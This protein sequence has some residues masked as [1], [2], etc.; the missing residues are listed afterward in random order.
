MIKNLYRNLY[1]KINYVKLKRM[2]KNIAFFASNF[3]EIV[4]HGVCEIKALSFGYRSFVRL[5]ECNFSEINI[6]NMLQQKLNL[7]VSLV[8]RTKLTRT[9]VKKNAYRIKT[10]NIATWNTNT[11]LPKLE[12]V[13]FL[14]KVTRKQILPSNIYRFYLFWESWTKI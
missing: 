6:K 2:I 10:L 13:H 14:V 8:E 5:L 4:C 9:A 7:K 12:I 1:L 11:F 3:I